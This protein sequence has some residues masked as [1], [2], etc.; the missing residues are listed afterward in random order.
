VIICPRP[1]CRGGEIAAG[2]L[3]DVV[4]YS[5]DIAPDQRMEDLAHHLP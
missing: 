4:E 1:P 3:E 2:G 5:L